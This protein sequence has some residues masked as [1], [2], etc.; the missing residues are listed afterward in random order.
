MHCNRPQG[1]LSCKI[2]W[3]C[4]KIAFANHN[5]YSLNDGVESSNIFYSGVGLSGLKPVILLSIN[6]SC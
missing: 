4:K 2:S 5:Y 6:Y 1:F 3:L